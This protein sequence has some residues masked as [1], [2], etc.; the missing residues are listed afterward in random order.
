MSGAA[1]LHF[2]ALLNA[3]LDATEDSGWCKT[4]A[5]LANHRD[6]LLHVA[7]MHEPYLSLLLEGTKTVESRFSVKRIQPFGRVQAGDVLALK[8]QSGPVV[9][10]A[11][12]ADA[13]FYELTPAL[14]HELRSEYEIQLA[15]TEDE[16]WRE[17]ERA[18]FASLIEVR[19]PY[20]LD[21]IQ[22]KK[23]DRRGWAVLAPGVGSLGG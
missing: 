14:F 18:G 17:R 11:L 13:R 21:G 10:L 8:R 3:L 6:R 23:R 4:L 20:P 19:N 12:V 5:S 7:V 22:L 1:E 15:A 16:F 9:G 2:D